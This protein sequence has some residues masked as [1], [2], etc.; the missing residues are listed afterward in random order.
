MFAPVAISGLAA[1]YGLYAWY[2][3]GPTNASVM[4]DVTGPDGAPADVPTPADVPVTRPQEPTIV[5]VVDSQMH[6]VYRQVLKE[7]LK[8][9]KTKK[10]TEDLVEFDKAT[11]KQASER[12]L[13]PR[14]RTGKDALTHQLAEVIDARYHS[15]RGRGDE[16]IKDK[17][18]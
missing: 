17:D 13:R 3:S 2:S 16:L 4:V 18:L 9:K 5:Y 1:A 8:T 10:L 6:D 12:K 11:L 14:K 7:I 15:L